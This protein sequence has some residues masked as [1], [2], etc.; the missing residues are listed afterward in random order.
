M[1]FAVDEPV[2]DDE[3]HAAQCVADLVAEGAPLFEVGLAVESQAEWGDFDVG[4][5]GEG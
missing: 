2:A 5:E 3:L 4:S 1:V